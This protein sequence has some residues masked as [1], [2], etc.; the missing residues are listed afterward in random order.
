[1]LVQACE[2]VAAEGK[3]AVHDPAV[4]LIASRIGFASP[5]D[6]MS[7]DQWNMLINI[8]LSGVE[9]TIGLRDGIT[10]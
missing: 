5:A 10:Q 3:S 7:S 4:A 9:G 2:E 1:M 6:V 8:C